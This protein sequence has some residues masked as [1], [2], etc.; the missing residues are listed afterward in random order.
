MIMKNLSEQL[1]CFGVCPPRSYYVPFAAGQKN[2]KR[3]SSDLFLSLN[4]EWAL[5][6]YERIEEIGEDFCKDDLPDRISVPSCVQ[7]FGYDH[8]QYTNIR[9]PIPF[10]PPRV[11][12]QNPAFHYSRTFEADGTEGL[13]LVFEGVDSCFYVYVNGQ[14]VGFSQISHRISEFDITDFVRKGVNRLDVIVQKWCAGTYFEDQDKWRFTGIFR[15]VYLLKRSADHLIDYKIT[16]VLSGTDAEVTFS[17]LCGGADAEVSFCGEKKRV[18]VGETATFLVKD[19]RLWSAETPYLYDMLIACAGEVIFERVGVRAIV[20]ADGVF[21]LNGQ[22]IKLYGVNRHD[23]HPEKGAAVSYEDMERDIRLMKQLNVN[24]VRTSHYPS[25]PEFYRMCD[26]YGLYVI[27][28]SDLETHGVLEL[29]SAQGGMDENRR[30]ALLSDD[31]QY[32]DTYIERQI[33]NVEVHKNRP[34]VIIWSLG[35]ESGYGCNIAAA[36]AE[37]KKRD[38]HP[39]HYESHIHMER[40]ARDKEYYSS[41]VNILSRMYPSVEWMRDE[42]LPDARDRRPLLLCEYAHAM[43]NGPGGLKEYWDLM[44]S[45][46]RFLGGCIWE[47]ADHGV[48]YHGAPFRYGGDFGERT[49]DGNFC[50]DG[51]V[52]PD[53]QE[54]SGTREMKRVYQPVAF[55]RTEKGIA[56]FNKNYFAPLVGELLIVRKQDGRELSRERMQLALAPRS[57]LEIACASA[58]VI[59]T[60]L[61]V[62]GEERA[63]GAFFANNFVPQKVVSDAEI[64]TRRGVI[65]VHT[66]NLS[67]EICPVTGELCNITWKGLDLGRIALTIRRAPTD[68]DTGVDRSLFGAWNEA[69]SILIEGDAIVVRGQFVHESRKPML[70][71]TLRYTF[72]T[73][74]VQAEAAWEYPSYG[75]YVPRFGLVSKLPA[76]FSRLR[77][78]AYGPGE[79]YIDKHLGA[80]KD[81]FESNVAD[82]YEHGYI[83]PQESGSHFDPDFAELS[84]GETVL[85][86]EGMQSFCAIP[87]SAET[88]SEAKHDDELPA[89]DAV[90]FTLDFGMSGI[91][92]RSC[93]PKLPLQYRLSAKGEGRIVLRFSRADCK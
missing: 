80:Y 62:G 92:S 24:A 38:A 44:E 79:S 87:Y 74:G 7:Y 9:Y 68:N 53:R 8:F 78:C 59:L 18:S 1:H 72:G 2:G 82:E 85:R 65:A 25:A 22:P 46:E 6:A 15:D 16:T 64:I 49:H 75:D 27:S 51:I 45:S 13:Y 50:I 71:Y 40:P 42:F 67:C 69:R 55:T 91:G 39:V 47:W 35:N 90:Y 17:Y 33:C 84:D 83:K 86:A 29:G 10:D 93:G 12:V 61:F 21:F 3:E 73:E 19:V 56:L 28:E 32:L 30:F 4:G 58:Q 63:F 77:Y 31:S 88:L 20:I 66:K 37:V 76:R 89:S 23:F 34:C 5:R 57:A 26:E 60:T 70:L 14:Y 11:P 52:T 41:V 81:V 36:S 48:S 54:K 43:G